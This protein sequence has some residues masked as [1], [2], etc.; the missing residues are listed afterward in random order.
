M[1]VDY[2]LRVTYIDKRQN[3]RT[4]IN[5]IEVGRAS[6]ADPIFANERAEALKI[7][8]DDLN[9]RT[10]INPDFVLATIDDVEVQSVAAIRT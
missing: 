5:L 4:P 8:V 10:R 6:D 2:T 7:A 9:N 3:S 1:I